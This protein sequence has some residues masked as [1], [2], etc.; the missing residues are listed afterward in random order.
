MPAD[1]FEV[2]YELLSRWLM[3]AIFCICG[4]AYIMTTVILVLFLYWRNEPEI[5]AT[6]PYL[7][8]AMFAG[9]YLLY[10]AIVFE[11]VHRSFVIG[12]EAFTA[13]CNTDIWFGFIGYNLI[14]GTLFVKLLRINQT[15]R[16]FRK[17][18]KLWSD[19]FLFLGVLLI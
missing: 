7:S 8:L 12:F 1:Q 16:V 2:V 3:I 17:T 9:C 18:S 11:T 5:K 6:S 14:I 10:I 13:I 4:L 19:Q 15:F